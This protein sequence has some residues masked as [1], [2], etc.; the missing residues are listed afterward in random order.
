MQ[1]GITKK[2]FQGSIGPCHHL[3]RKGNTGNR[4]LVPWLRNC[5]MGFLAA[6]AECRENLHLGMCWL[7]KVLE[8]GSVPGIPASLWCHQFW[9]LYHLFSVEK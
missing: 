3:T 6:S 8:A 2:P 4:H 5:W 7:L 1:L 9:W